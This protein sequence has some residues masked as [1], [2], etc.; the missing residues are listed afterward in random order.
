MTWKFHSGKPLSKNTANA[1]GDFILFPRYCGMQRF[2]ACFIYFVF[3]FITFAQLPNK[4]AVDR[5]KQGVKELRFYEGKNDSV[6]ATTF[7]Y[8]H[9]GRVTKRVTIEDEAYENGLWRIETETYDSLG[10]LVKVENQY[11]ADNVPDNIHFFPGRIS[12]HS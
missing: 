5:K 12:V 9:K 4:S 8:D 7:F 6:P 2:L 10:R 11:S 3:P 1:L